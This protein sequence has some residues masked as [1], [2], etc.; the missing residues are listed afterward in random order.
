M[1][2]PVMSR[3]SLSE[4]SLFQKN[5]KLALDILDEFP[6][7]QI[8]LIPVW[9]DDCEPSDERLYK[10]KHA[11]LFPDYQNGLNEI[12]RSVGSQ[13]RIKRISKFGRC[14]FALEGERS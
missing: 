13:Q 3:K 6:D 12:L 8:Y 9:V 2:V 4:R 11:D 5:L 1:F 7:N 14:A 10:R